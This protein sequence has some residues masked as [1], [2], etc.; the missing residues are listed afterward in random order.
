MPT[1]LHEDSV[2]AY[3]CPCEMY[4]NNEIPA[5]S[6]IATSYYKIQ[7]ETATHYYLTSKCMPG[8]SSGGVLVDRLGRAVAV[9]VTAYTPKLYVPHTSAVSHE[10]DSSQGPLSRRYRRSGIH[11]VYTTRPVH[12]PVRHAPPPPII[13]SG[14]SRMRVINRFPHRIPCAHTI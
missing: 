3:Y 7:I 8:L 10:S 13:N 1:T 14:Y 2:K 9:I 12:R 11:Q 4:K 6:F 5:L